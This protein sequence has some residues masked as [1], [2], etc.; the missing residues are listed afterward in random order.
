MNERRAQPRRGWLLLT[1]FAAAA[2]L[3]AGCATT[4]GE[5]Q[6]SVQIQRTKHGIAHIQ[7]VDFESLGYGIAY[8]H[9]QDNFC[10]TANH[11]VT[12]RGKRS[13]Y[14]GPTTVSA[15]GL[16]ALPNSVIDTF[17]ASHMDDKRLARAHSMQSIESQDLARGYVAGYNRFLSEASGGRPQCFNEPWITPMTMADWRRFTEITMVQ[18]GAA[19]LADAIASATPPAIT[20][21]ADQPVFDIERAV[22]AV[23]GVGLLDPKMGSNGWAFGKDTTKNGRGVLLGNPHFPWRGVNRFWQ[24]HLTVPGKLDVMGATIG[25][26]PIVNIGFTHNL[27]WTHTVSTGK[28]FTLHQLKLVP[29]K[30]TRYI[31]DGKPEEMQR[32]TVRYDALIDGNLVER[33]ATTWYT[34]YGPI[35][36]MPPAGL[37]WDTSKAFAL[38]DA[39]SGNQRSIDSWIGLA[40]AKDASEA[41]SAVS[42]LGIPWVNTIAASREGEALYIDASVVPDVDAAKFASCLPDPRAQALFV[43]A[44]LP[45]LDGSRSECD[46]TKDASSPV[47]GLTPIA[48]MP[49]TVRT[50]W[51]QNSNDSFWLANPKAPLSAGSPLVGLQREQQRPRTRTGILEIQEMLAAGRVDAAAVQATLF[52]NRNYMG[53]ILMNDLDAACGS[54]PS[55]LAK[56][57]CQARRK[58]DRHN[59]RESMGAHLFREFWRAAQNVAG[60]YRVAFNPD[61]PI[62]TPAGL[63]F[64]GDAGPKIWDALERA[65]STTKANGIRLD[66]S[67]GEVQTMD[68]KPIHG[69]DEFEGVLNKVQTL[70]VNRLTANGYEVDYGTS[71]VQAVEFDQIGP[72]AR[73]I[74]VYGQS[75]DP[76]SAYFRDQLGA[77]ARKEWVELPFHADDVARERIGQPLTLKLK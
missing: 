39:N 52:R 16:R 30:P 12:V 72:R 64:T 54:A 74:L 45:I 49:S 77:Y 40:R 26:F 37:T 13:K 25:H 53:Q 19:A 71:Y 68:K 67:L 1:A 48:R 34:R 2:S 27:A 22:A 6:R 66:A 59:N 65:V 21:S 70:A 43:R 41:K 15:F 69:G 7:A 33:S 20:G 31:V 35:V 44:G 3:A 46:W 51:V 75:T 42:N 29:G 38:Q 76:T 36:N 56:E 9:A 57:G 47:P 32:R 4:S 8:A 73:A 11:I 5:S 18:A 24:M 55:A 28:R 58:W 10:Q 61:D 63:N 62:H 14:F 17:V 23:A 50:D 60:V